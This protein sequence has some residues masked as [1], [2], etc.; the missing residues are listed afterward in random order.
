[1]AMIYTNN[2]YR[3]TYLDV[4]VSPVSGTIDVTVYQQDA[5]V[6]TVDTV[7]ID[8]DRLY[9]NLPFSLTQNDNK[10]D[11]RWI[12]NYVEDGNTFEYDGWTQESVVTPILPLREI[13]AI[14]EVENDDAAVGEIEKA[15]RY[16]IQSHT[17][18]FFGKYIGTI[19]VSGVGDPNLRLPRRLIS[20]TTINGNNLMNEHLVLRGNGW[21]LK[22]KSYIGPPS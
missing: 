21:Y 12:F 17:G 20:Y 7:Y 9:F 5:E 1:M 19:S 18:Q 16:I 6:F 4:P 2:A 15:V 14:L 3:R 13:A 22:S 8:D 11:I 10:Y